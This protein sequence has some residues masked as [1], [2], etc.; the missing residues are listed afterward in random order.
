M[1]EQ[2]RFVY[3]LVYNNQVFYIGQT[4]NLCHRYAWHMNSYSF[5]GQIT[6]TARFIK[7]IRDMEEWPFMHIIDYL[8]KEAALQLEHQLIQC[9][10]QAGHF[11]TNITGN[12]PPHTLP[13]NIPMKL[14]RKDMMK[15]I[16][17]TQAKHLPLVYKEL[18]PHPSEPFVINE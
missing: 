11:L 4:T 8:P 15:V 17:F 2:H 13:K 14:T 6:E 1:K 10:T 3:S 12:Y 9:L 16:S 7:N 5:N 18:I